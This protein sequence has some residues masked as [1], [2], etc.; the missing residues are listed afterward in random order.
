MLDR[1]EDNGILPDILIPGELAFRWM[2][3]SEVIEKELKR[4]EHRAHADQV[5]ELIHSRHVV[6]DL[7]YYCR[8]VVLRNEA[9]GLPEVLDGLRDL[10]PEDA[11]YTYCEMVVLD[12]GKDLP[13]GGL[14][15]VWKFKDQ[16]GREL[17]DDGYLADDNQFPSGPKVWEGGRDTQWLF[18]LK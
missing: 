15:W 14:G 4:M 1:Q 8:G 16:W 5:N 10:A 7:M 18:S 11:E 3:A 17:G 6:R 12:P 9:A 13:L 2:K